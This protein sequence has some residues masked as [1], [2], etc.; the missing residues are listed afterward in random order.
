MASPSRTLLN[1]ATTR[2][3]LIGVSVDSASARN[4][5]NFSLF[6][7][8]IEK[9]FP[10]FKSIQC[11]IQSGKA[12]ARI[13]DERHVDAV[14]RPRDRRIDVEVDDFRLS[15]R[16]VAPAL[17]GDR[18]GAAADEDDEVG[19][20]DDGARL[21]RAAVRADDARGERVPL[22]DRALAADAGG[23]RGGKLLR[24]SSNSLSA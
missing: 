21:G 9:R 6:C 13:A 11:F 19:G 17:G 3:G 8:S 4:F 20:I 24:S 16:R 7:C 18:A 10:F 2:S 12:K 14:V 23:D 22:V 15:R 1:S 5:S